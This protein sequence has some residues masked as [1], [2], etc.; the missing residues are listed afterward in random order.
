MRLS[1]RFFRYVVLVSVVLNLG[2]APYLDEIFDDLEQDSQT[3]SVSYSNDLDP[4]S[5]ELQDSSK[6]TGRAFQ[7]LL[8]SLQA[9]VAEPLLLPVLTA[10]DVAR[11][12]MLFPDSASL[13]RID[14]PP[15][16]DS[17]VV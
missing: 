12:E 1:A 11:Q 13:D 14:R 17:S 5:P 7:Q 9:L 2:D 10:S 8:L 16:D 4:V 3:L 15:H 6:H